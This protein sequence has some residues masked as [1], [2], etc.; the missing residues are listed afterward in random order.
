MESP[1]RFLALEASFFP[2]RERGRCRLVQ[3]EIELL[4]R[5]QGF[6]QFRP[7]LGRH[8]TEGFEDVFL[9]FRCYLCL[10]QGVIRPAIDRIKADYI[11]AAQTPNRSCDISFRART[12]TEITRYLRCHFGTRGLS[13]EFQ[14]GAG[15]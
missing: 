5:I 8:L 12:L 13:H 7:K 10:Y 3:G 11:L 6:A 9:I 2:P 15:S 14:C 4:N 1:P